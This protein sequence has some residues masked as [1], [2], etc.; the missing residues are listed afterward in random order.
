MLSIVWHQVRDVTASWTP[1]SQLCVTTPGSQGQASHQ[2]GKHVGLTA[3]Q[4]P[5]P[6]LGGPHGSVHL[7]R[8]AMAVLE[9][10]GG[11]Q[12]AAKSWSW[13]RLPSKGY[14]PAL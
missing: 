6:S 9:G 14:T 10:P 4:S 13:L 11:E 1:A 2:V 3:L 8:L 12:E 7:T 5:R